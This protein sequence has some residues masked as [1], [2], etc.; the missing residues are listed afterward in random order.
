MPGTGPNQNLEEI[1]PVVTTSP[2]LHRRGDRPAAAIGNHVRR[3]GARGRTA[4]RIIAPPCAHLVACNA[5]TSPAHHRP[6]KLSSLRNAT[7]VREG[8][9][10]RC[11]T[12]ARGSAHRRNGRPPKLRQLAGN[13]AR[14]LARGGTL[15]SA[16]SGTRA[17][18]SDTILAVSAR[19]GTRCGSAACGGAGRSTCD[20]ISI[21]DR[22]QI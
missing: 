22:F 9:A 21:F 19:I 10:Q 20:D 16:S 11:A 12:I 8:G 15:R 2:E 18:D 13:E 14:Q 17:S 7:A 3:K 1:R 5:S 4:A 6:T